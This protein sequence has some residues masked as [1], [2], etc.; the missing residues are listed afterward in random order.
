[1]NKLLSIAL[2]MSLHVHSAAGVARA[3]I[4]ELDKLLPP[5]PS[6]PKVCIALKASLVAKNFRLPDEV[7]ADPKNSNPDTERLIMAMNACPRGQAVKI[8]AEGEKNAFLAGPIE[9]KS[10]VSLW[11]DK[12]VTLFASRSPAD[13]DLGDGYCGTAQP[14][15]K[16]RCKTW[17]TAKNTVGSGIVGEGVIDGRGGSVLT[18]GP[19]AG[20]TTW[21]DLSIQ[22]KAKPKLEQN[23]PRMIE[24]VGGENFT[25]YKI[26]ITNGAK[27]HV[28][29]K[30]VTGLTFWGIKVITP[31]LA[32]TVP[33]YKCGKGT[34]PEPGNLSRPSSCF[35]P[36]LVKNTDAID[37]GRSKN[38]TLAY[39]YITTGDD[40]V[41]IKSGKGKNPPETINHL[42][43]HNQFY[44]GHGM[45]IGSETDAG[46]ENIKIWDLNF[47]G[48]DS[49]HGVGLRIKTDGKRGGEIS[50][51][52]YQ[53]V[54]L[55]RMKDVLVFSPYYSSTKDTNHPPNIH[56]V[57]LRNV[58][59]VDY[60]GAKYNKAKVS[61]SGY[62]TDTVVNPLKIQLDNVVF[63]QTPEL[64]KKHYHD[65]EF[66]L[67]PGAVTNLPIEAGE[68]ISVKKIGEGKSKP[69]PCPDSVFKS[70]PSE[71][72]PI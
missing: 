28:A 60:P 23:N 25:F 59:Y 5:E 20:K 18:S 4:N 53:D 13:Y 69:F 41:A 68:S 70:I 51:V 30:D 35:I 48:Q 34:M 1:M 66:T 33:G 52:L 6:F 22:S 24:V 12:G 32:Y 58:H 7:D 42:Y 37:P 56:D 36:E 55:R 46:V 15:I 43:A 16:N 29:S 64:R 50:N 44:Y 65:V 71:L 11:V 8:I 2:L 45:S 10:G 54:C 62:R 47:D 19:Y 26:T 40:N 63:D 38:V 61:F 27:F 67:G 17:I 39:S 49:G 3:E 9:I 14:K 72:S 57:V 31:S 21:W